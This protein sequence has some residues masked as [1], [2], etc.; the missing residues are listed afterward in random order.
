MPSHYHTDLQA[1]LHDGTAVT[2]SADGSVA[3]HDLAPG[4]VAPGTGVR[5]N[6]SAISQTI[7]F[8]GEVRVS[9]DGFVSERTVGSVEIDGLGSF[10]AVFDNQQDGKIYDEVKVRFVTG[11]TTPSISSSADITGAA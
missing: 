1:S 8:F 4:H 9:D 3:S 7:N 2:T 5:F 10:F 11:G 6:V